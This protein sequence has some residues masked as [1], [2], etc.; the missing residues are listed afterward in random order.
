MEVERSR[1]GV[2]RKEQKKNTDLPRSHSNQSD[3]NAGVR[4]NPDTP[5]L[6]SI[7][8]DLLNTTFLNV[9]TNVL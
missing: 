5:I 7:L 6:S 3:R 4:L 2:L 8:S 9:L 1:R